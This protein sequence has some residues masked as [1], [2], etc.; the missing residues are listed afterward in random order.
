MGESLFLLAF[1]LTT[2]PFLIN[3]KGMVC[4]VHDEQ[5]KMKLR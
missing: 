1:L 3:Q 4:D 5:M 2:P